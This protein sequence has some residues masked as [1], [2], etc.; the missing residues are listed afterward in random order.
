MGF[1]NVR[2]QCICTK[3]DLYNSKDDNEALESVTKTQS[4]FTII[5]YNAIKTPVTN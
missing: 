3:E 5:D 2:Y 1:T 4:Y